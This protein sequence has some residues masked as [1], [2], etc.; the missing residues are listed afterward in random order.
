MNSPVK[1]FLWMESGAEEAARFYTSLFADGNVT[2]VTRFPIG[3]EEGQEVVTVEFCLGGSD[4][5]IMG[6]PGC[7]KPNE[8]FS[9]SVTCADQAEVDRLWDALVDGGEPLQCGWLR[10]R[11]GFCWQITPR[12]MYELI[13]SGNAAQ[14][15]AT[16]QA[17]MTMVKFD[18][19][20]LDAAYASV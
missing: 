18:I 20:A 5:V 13:E 11:F 3:P 10:D 16:M 2:K 15:L 19:A 14:R 8:T 12:R 7:P 4:Y 9:F 17:M 1:T 6:S